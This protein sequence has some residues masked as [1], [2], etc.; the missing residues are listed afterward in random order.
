VLQVSPA[1]PGRM[2]E[3]TALMTELIKGEVVT[4]A[5]TGVAT[6]PVADAALLPHIFRELDDRGIELAEFTLRKASGPPCLARRAEGSQGGLA[7][8]LSSLCTTEHDAE[9]A[10]HQRYGLGHA[11]VVRGERVPHRRFLTC[12]SQPAARRAMIGSRMPSVSSTA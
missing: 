3:V 6:A 5:A 8:G 11:Q 1:D 12:F 10:A 4:D 7:V 2:P 9:R